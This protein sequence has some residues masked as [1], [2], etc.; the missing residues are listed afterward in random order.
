MEPQQSDAGILLQVGICVWRRAAPSPELS[1][2]LA[3]FQRQPPWQT[4]TD[5]DMLRQTAN[6]RRNAR[7]R[8]TDVPVGVSAGWKCE[9]RE[10]L[11]QTN[12]EFAHRL[13]KK[14]G[15]SVKN[16]DPGH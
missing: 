10:T 12:D 6:E 15:A 9:N 2:T 8:P 11:T 5:G 1:R 4:N 16:N 13:E 14:T 7:G 3:R